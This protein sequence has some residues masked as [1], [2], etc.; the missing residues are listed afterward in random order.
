MKLRNVGVGR[1]WDGMVFA[2]YV[3]EDG[4]AVRTDEKARS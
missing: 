2:S 1:V 3:N 4:G